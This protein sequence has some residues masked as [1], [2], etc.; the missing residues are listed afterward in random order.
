MNMFDNYSIAPSNSGE[1]GAP[2]RY[3]SHSFREAVNA[4]RFVKGFGITAL[5]YS[6]V[7]MFGVSLLGGGIGLGADSLS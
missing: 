6:L 7:S 5:V 1:A 2:A 4:S 3:S